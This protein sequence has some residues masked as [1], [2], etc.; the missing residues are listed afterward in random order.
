M[1]LAT[2]LILL[3]QRQPVRSDLAEALTYL[4]RHQS[5]DG[6][7]GRR[8]GGCKCPEE[9]GPL[10]V[11]E[12]STRAKIAGLITAL[13]DETLEGRDLAQRA[14]REIG[15]VAIL[16]LRESAAQGDAEI[17]TRSLDLLRSL[18]DPRSAADLESTALALLALSGAG[19]SSRSPLIGEVDVAM[20]MKRGQTWL[21][22]R[23]GETG[24]F[25]TTSSAAQ[26]IASW[27]LSEILAMTEQQDL[28]EPL[29]KAIDFLAAHPAQ[30]GRG[31]FYQ[32]LALK[33]AELAQCR[34]PKD[35]LE[36]RSA[37]LGV[38]RAGE[39]WSILLRSGSL[40]ASVFVEHHPK[41][42]DYA[43]FPGL[44]PARLEP[45]TVYAVSLAMFQGDGPGGAAWTAWKEKRDA[46]TP[47]ERARDR[48]DRGSWK[49]EGT[50]ARVT[51]AALGA[52]SRE[53]YYIYSQTKGPK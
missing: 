46:T 31:L 45:E 43:G 51:S 41:S 28:K 47:P 7:W 22:G 26:A 42:L 6:S 19:Y 53:F 50:A 3:L 21:L 1:L 48:C 9:P 25:G 27:S 33:S 10:P 39:P 24:N 37:G 44:D 18:G 34:I 8:A 12:A 23:L 40:S 5:E 20:I 2:A 30:D 49:A 35:A 17:R 4:E 15:D 38:K 11:L 13:G 32:V 14:L 52:L 16:Q 29:E 36:R